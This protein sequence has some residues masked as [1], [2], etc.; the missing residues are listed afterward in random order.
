VRRPSR[1][2]RIAAAFVLGAAL[3]AAGFFLLTAPRPSGRVIPAHAS[4]P[5]NGEILFHAGDCIGCHKSA[6]GT[7]GSGPPAGGVAF[8]TPFGT[9]YP[10]NLTPDSSTGIGRWTAEE[11]VD[12]MAEGVS[13]D[14]RHYFPAFPYTSYRNMR[15][16]DLLDLRAYLMSLP[17]VRSSRHKADV[18]MVGLARRTV[19]LWKRFAFRRRTYRP[20]PDRSAAWNRGAYLVHGPG[21]CD[22][23]HTPRNAFMILDDTRL[24]EGGPHPRGEGRVP[25]LRDLLGRKRYADVGDLELALQFGETLG[26]DKLSS[27][28]MAEIQ[29]SLALLPAEDLEAI[30]EYLL[31]LR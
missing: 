15:V 23:C 17:P 30:S 12:A 25:S 16:E 3:V 19:G 22:E 14:G 2:R 26:Y 18:A 11:F 7:G 27:G 5:A 4:D 1:A 6:S 10:G 28:G 20:D 29:M 8:P 31:S 9:F 24:L 21:H 13:P